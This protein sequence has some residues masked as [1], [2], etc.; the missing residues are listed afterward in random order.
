MGEREIIPNKITPSAVHGEGHCIAVH[1]DADVGAAWKSSNNVGWE[2]DRGEGALA[3]R[4]RSPGT[5]APTRHKLLARSVLG[6]SNLC[7][8]SVPVQLVKGYTRRQG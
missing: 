8:R 2:A 3:V 6:G 1:G 5:A 7:L 4:S